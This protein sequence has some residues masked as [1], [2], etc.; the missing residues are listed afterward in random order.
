MQNEHFL[1][2]GAR[3]PPIFVKHGYY[4]I[5]HGVSSTGRKII[6][7]EKLEDPAAVQDKTDA[8]KA[9][10]GLDYTK[11]F[12]PYGLTKRELEIAGLIAEGKTNGD[13]ASV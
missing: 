3:F 8:E 11:R 7:S 1:F 9:E 12:Q 10:D 4:I 2:S 13:I 5:F 6:F